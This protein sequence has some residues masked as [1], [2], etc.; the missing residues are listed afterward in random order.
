MINKPVYIFPSTV[1]IVLISFPL[2]FK[3]IESFEKDN[4]FCLISQINFI[5]FISF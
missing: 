4:I 1:I 5:L 2:F 3:D